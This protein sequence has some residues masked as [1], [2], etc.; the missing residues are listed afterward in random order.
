MGAFDLVSDD[1]ERAINHNR[2]KTLAHYGAK[3]LGDYTKQ[4]LIAELKRRG[5]EEKI[6]RSLESRRE[7]H[8]MKIEQLQREI[9]REQQKLDKIK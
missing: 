4:E 3:S 6:K 1:D 2:S 9:E 7:P 5:K 8:K